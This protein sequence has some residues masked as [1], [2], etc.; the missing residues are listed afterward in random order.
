MSKEG[1]TPDDKLILT[2]YAID[3]WCRPVFKDYLNRLFGNMDLLCNSKHEA[4][5]KI[6]ET[7]IYY[8]GTDIEDDPDGTKINPAKIEIQW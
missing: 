6:D 7:K 8:F 5:D 3:F 2:F 1:Y 4:M